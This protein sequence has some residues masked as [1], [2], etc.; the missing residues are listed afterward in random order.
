MLNGQTIFLN[1]NLI[2]VVNWVT[3]VTLSVR[4]LM[5]SS[6][7]WA[8]LYPFV[9]GLCDRSLCPPD[10]RSSRAN[11]SC[12]CLCWHIGIGKLSLLCL[13][14]VHQRSRCIIQYFIRVSLLIIYIS[15]ITMA[16]QQIRYVYWRPWLACVCFQLARAC[17]QVAAVSGVCMPFMNV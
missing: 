16:Q 1:L 17:L 15:D 10:C 14:Q 12:L 6:W 5:Y 13:F 4:W 2:C 7:K 11:F 3:E 9:V 8:R